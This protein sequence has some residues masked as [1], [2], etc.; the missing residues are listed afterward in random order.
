MFK[1]DDV[2]YLKSLKKW[3]KSHSISFERIQTGRS[4]EIKDLSVKSQRSK[5]YCWQKKGYS[6]L[7]DGPRNVFPQRRN[8]IRNSTMVAD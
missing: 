3:D 1:C 7:S 8:P 2:T 5:S 4:N 6:N